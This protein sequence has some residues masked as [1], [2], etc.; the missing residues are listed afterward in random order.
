[1][2]A[3]IITPYGMNN[4]PFGDYTVAQFVEMVNKVQMTNGEYMRAGGWSKEDNV[5][6]LPVETSA[7]VLNLIFVHL[8]ADNQGAGIYT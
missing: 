5:Y 2:Q 3:Q 1:M 8:L 4:Q 6:K 7:G